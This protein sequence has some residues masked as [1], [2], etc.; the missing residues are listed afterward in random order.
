MN[1]ERTPEKDLI[2]YIEIPRHLSKPVSIDTLLE[3]RMK[4]FLRARR[5]RQLKTK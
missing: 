2:R 3:K 5:L 4:A 1:M